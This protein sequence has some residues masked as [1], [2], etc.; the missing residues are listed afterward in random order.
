MGSGTMET[1]TSLLTPAGEN[2]E[3][4]SGEGWGLWNDTETEWLIWTQL[5]ASSLGIRTTNPNHSSPCS[6]ASCDL[7]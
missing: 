7:S 3:R 2:V 5:P 6:L 1:L 4:G